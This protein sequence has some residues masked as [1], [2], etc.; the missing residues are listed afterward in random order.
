M[1][2]LLLLAVVLL[3]I[4]LLAQTGVSADA[5]HNPKVRAI[6]A[7]VRLDRSK[8]EQQIAE[9]LTVLRKAQHEFEAEG[10]QVESLRI[11]TQPVG[12]LVAGLSEDDAVSFLARFDQLSAKENFI[13]NVGPAMM[14]DS[15]DP[16]TMRV[17]ER[18]LSTLPNIEASTIIADD[19]GIHWK[20]I[21]RTAE[22]VKYVA[23]H[24]PHAQGTFNFTATAMLK[25]L[26]PFYPGSYH[27]GPGRQFS[28][29][30]EGAGLVAEVFTRDKGNAAAAT[31]DLTAALSK[32]AKVAEAVG[33]KVAAETG[34]GFAG[35]D[36][37]PA[38]LGDV[39][40]ATAIEDFTGAKFGSS[41][42]L[43]AARIITAAVKA[44]PV[45]QIGYSGLMVPIME[46]K[47][48]AQRW[49]EGMF[50][51]DSLL[52]YSAVCGTGLDTIPL[53]GNISTEQMERMFSDVASLASKWNKPLSARLQPVPGK[54]AGEMTEFQDPYLFNTTIHAAP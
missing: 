31:A 43:T 29:G 33:N 35:V 20:T 50:N 45:K 44:V 16:A 41:G 39:S 52:A 49:A 10:Y 8:W 7:F 21:H 24:S 37:T 36:P 26:G 1:K 11:T 4:Q 9:T 12:E 30:F 22:L 51:V 3:P 53:P 2:R 19:A 28:I 34:W 18:A 32:H 27:D 15:D 6:T 23:E 46:D 13:P 40:I 25:P 47:V 38:P 14:H 42:T 54:K 5:S 17:L 48:M